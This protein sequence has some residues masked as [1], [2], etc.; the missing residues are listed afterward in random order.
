MPINDQ[1]LSSN[2][3]DPHSQQHVF[4][5]QA[6]TT[7]EQILVP[8]GLV[9]TAPRANSG[10][11]ARMP[12]T[13]TLNAG[14]GIS[15]A[16]ARHP[17]QRIGEWHN[18]PTH[19]RLVEPLSH[20]NTHQRH[21]ATLMQ[22]SSNPNSESRPKHIRP[23]IGSQPY[24]SG[25]TN[26]RG[27]API[28][29]DNSRKPFTHL[30]RPSRGVRQDKGVLTN[31]ASASL[32]PAPDTKSIRVQFS[33]NTVVRSHRVP[34]A[35]RKPSRITLWGIDPAIMSEL[36]HIASQEGLSLSQ[37]GKTALGQWIHQR[38]H[39]KHEAMLYPVL[40]QLFRDELRHFG[41]RIIFFLMRIAFAA[42]QTRILVTNI[43]SRF[44]KYLGVPDETFNN[45]VDQSN[46]MAK[47]NIIAG[48]P[49]IKSLMEE[50]QQSSTNE[51]NNHETKKK[52]KP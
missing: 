5:R 17:A 49:Q 18:H 50:W 26:S 25:Y 33:N 29:P 24:S 20:P 21:A 8:S 39:D 1:V 34:G 9:P 36:E 6:D 11:V 44:L 37:V 22:F 2:N 19:T 45:L 48:S 31:A 15:R 40:R 10:G 52:E 51:E 46:R 30:K 38:L 43:L 14:N 4:S 12:R 42:E 3:I 28:D 16:F 13:S 23:D 47:R 41:N 7:T 32:Q 35:R 27:D